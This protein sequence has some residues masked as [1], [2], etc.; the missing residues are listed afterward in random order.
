VT[1][2]LDKEDLANLSNEKMSVLER[3]VVREILDDPHLAAR[4]ASK[5]KSLAKRR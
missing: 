4:L 1:A 5:I 2:L 3:V